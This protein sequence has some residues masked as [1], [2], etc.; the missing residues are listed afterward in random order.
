AWRQGG[1][2]G[3]ELAHGRES[4]VGMPD[5]IDLPS[6]RPRPEVASLRGA[7]SRTRV[8][9]ETVEGLQAL[10]RREGATFYMTLLAAFDVLLHR[11]SG[12]D[13]IALGVPVDARDRRELEDLI[14]VFVDTVVLRI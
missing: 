2:L 7:W 14:G 3:G 5:A 10:A 4:L 12:Q 11:Y 8:P 13:D 1:L 6:D 9:A